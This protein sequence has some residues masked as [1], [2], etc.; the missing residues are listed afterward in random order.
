MAYVHFR[1]SCVIIWV[2]LLVSLLETN[3]L[4][5][6]TQ[7]LVTPLSVCKA[8]ADLTISVRKSASYPSCV[9]ILTAGIYVFEDLPEDDWRDVV[10]LKDVW[11]GSRGQW[12]WGG[13]RSGNWILGKDAGKVAA[14]TGEHR[15]MRVEAFFICFQY[16]IRQLVLLIPVK[17]H[18]WIWIETFISGTG[19]F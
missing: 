13:W 14:V 1:P 2:L 8:Q 17:S 10:D 7:Q 6:E 3:V 18:K 4:V 9:C 5:L 15:A 19:Q 16:H 12:T 11:S